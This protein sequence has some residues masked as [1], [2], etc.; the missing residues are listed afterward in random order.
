M[1]VPGQEPGGFAGTAEALEAA[2]AGLGY[3]AGADAASLPM[4]ELAG[5][6]R[7]LE[8]V[9]S[10]QTAARAGILAA[11]TAQ[12]GYVDDGQGAPGAWLRWQ[13]R[14]TRGAASGAVGWMRRLAAHP[15]VRDALAAAEISSSLARELC[16][17]S[18]R[19]P[20]GRRQDADA[21][22]L[23]AHAGGADLAD[24]AALAEEMLRRCGPPDGDDG[25]RGFR[26][27]GVQLDLHYR[28]AGKLSGD[29]TPECAAGL[30]AVLESLGKKAGPEDDRTRPQR[31]HDALEEMCRRLAAAGGLPD[32]AGQPAQVV[33]HA[34]LDQLRSLEGA[35][36]AEAAWAAGQAAGDGRPGWL[37]SRAAAEAYAC[38]A[39]IAPLI[40]GHIDPVALAVEIRM[41]LDARQRPARPGCQIAGCPGQD[42]DSSGG[43]S[44]GGAGRR[45]RPLGD[46]SAL[47]DILVRHAADVLSGP[48]GLAA[49]L[50][51]GLPGPQAA[52]A[53]LPLDLG[54]PTRT[55]P[56]HLR[57]AVIRRDRRCAF[58]GC[59]Q[60]PAGCQV[61]HLIP[62][63]RGGPTALHNLALVCSFHH[64]IAIHRWGWTL[65]LNSDGTTT[66]ISPDGH[67]TLH[68]HGPPAT[69]A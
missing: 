53:S 36:G 41:F 34:T 37:A 7:A 22:L 69:V 31:F 46:V 8:G 48:A 26:D 54:A 15:V 14:V 12:A 52:G 6:L 10:V 33:L 35:A 28:G 25:D 60:R 38:D 27:R 21:I 63:S 57:G 13:T 68:S 16:K 20:E 61:H 65:T 66:A 29:L 50:R 67:R 17:L 51:T 47:S 64:L 45:P 59:T 44:S 11:F 58:P 18:D 43:A 9:E 1:C 4:G 23:A 42:G 19:L 5:C 3:L 39:R 2:V 40:C 56:P 30:S 62:R 49:A 24:L 32:V 55:V